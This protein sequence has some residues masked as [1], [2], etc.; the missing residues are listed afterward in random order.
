M[1]EQTPGHVSNTL[2]VGTAYHDRTG[3]SGAGD[4]LI[5]MIAQVLVAW[6]TFQLDHRLSLVVSHA[7]RKGF[8]SLVISEGR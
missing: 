2:T 3:R 6:L 4:W 7:P 1:A 8:D 5:P